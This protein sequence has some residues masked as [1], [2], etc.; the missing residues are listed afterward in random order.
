MGCIGD[1]SDQCL[2]WCLLLGWLVFADVVCMSYFWGSI[3]DDYLHR[4]G[5]AL[6]VR[7]KCLEIASSDMLY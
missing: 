5:I 6:R 1:A 3:L 7:E 2:E 4:S